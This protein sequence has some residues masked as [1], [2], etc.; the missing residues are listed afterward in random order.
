MFLAVHFECSCL[1]VSCTGLKWRETQT[2]TFAVAT[3]CDQD[4]KRSGAGRKHEGNVWEEIESERADQW[5]RWNCSYVT[6]V[7]VSPAWQGVRVGFPPPL[8]LRRQLRSVL[9]MI[10]I[11][12]MLVIIFSL[13]IFSP[14]LL[15][16]IFVVAACRAL[17]GARLQQ[18]LTR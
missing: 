15:V 18:L 9:R 6:E 4:L 14:I 11:T 3:S 8:Q 1:L 13:F 7:R 17:A 16:I 5:Q 12:A 10:K 2:F